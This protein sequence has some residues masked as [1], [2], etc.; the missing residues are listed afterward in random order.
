MGQSRYR[1]MS[2]H[3]EVG[4]D[5]KRDRPVHL[6]D[7]KSTQCGAA[8]LMPRAGAHNPRSPRLIR[9]RQPPAGD[10]ADAFPPCRLSVTPG[11]NRRSSITAE[12]S[13]RY[14]GF[15]RCALFG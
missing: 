15:W 1:A 9:L 12:S 6:A 8:V 2:G 3:A 4:Y 14:T 5:G 11:N 7:A 13:P 10:Y